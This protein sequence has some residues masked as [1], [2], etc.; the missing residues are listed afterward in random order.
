ML[1]LLV[2]GAHA[3]QEQFKSW[4]RSNS[5]LVLII[6]YLFSI[7]ELKTETEHIVR[8]AYQ[9]QIKSRAQKYY[10]MNFRRSE[11]N[12]RQFLHFN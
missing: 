1:G 9:K 4:R 11:L 12:M 5:A 7:S 3:L 6:C 2:L 10:L 8:T